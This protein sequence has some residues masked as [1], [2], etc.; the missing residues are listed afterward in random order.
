MG[1][2]TTSEL[3]TA[4]VEKGFYDSVAAAAN[5][6]IYPSIAMTI[7]QDKLVANYVSFGSVPEPTQL[8]GKSGAKLRESKELKDY[9]LTITLLEWEDTI[10]LP[11]VVLESNPAVGGQKAGQMGAK[12]NVFFDKRM[13][14][15]FG[16]NP[17]S[18]D[19]AAF[20]STTHA[21]SGSNQINTQ[22]TNIAAASSPFTPT[23]AEL[24]TSLT[25]LFAGLKG[26]TD[27]QGTPVNEGVSR[28]TAL[29]HPQFEW[30]F[31]QVTDPTMSAQSVDSSGATGKFRGLVDVKV[32]AF[33]TA[34]GTTAGTVDRFYLV[35]NNV[36][37]KPIALFTQVPWAV[38]TNIGTDSDAWN[39]DHLCLITGYS[40]WEIG[41]WD[42]K[43]IFRQVY[44]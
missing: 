32:S 40:I 28:F 24:E 36:A 26:L 31:R 8:S 43:T 10:D 42:W 4:I 16:L 38:K 12:T 3:M 33:C 27:D 14:V 23:A 5:E 41:P 39:F 1:Y 44:T 21:E 18:Y 2:P 9:K 35:A 29:I 15:Q 7:P 25:S 13:F 20:F 6:R 17:N 19:T 11:R 30:V 37:T 34:D 22:S